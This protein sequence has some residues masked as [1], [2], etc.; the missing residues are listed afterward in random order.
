MDLVALGEISF[1]L[2]PSLDVKVT[3]ILLK[4][5]QELVHLGVEPQ[6]PLQ[7]GL[8]LIASLKLQIRGAQG[9]LA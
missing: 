1:V 2:M 6:K 9:W 7:Q 8:L 4:Y 3:R 5:P